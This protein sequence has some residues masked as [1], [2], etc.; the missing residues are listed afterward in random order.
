MTK[1]EFDN[2]K[3]GDAVKWKGSEH[4]LCVSGI[5]FR[6]YDFRR[7]LYYARFETEFPLSPPHLIDEN[8]DDFTVVPTVKFEKKWQAVEC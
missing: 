1:T 6:G 2:L 3:P 5:A 8:L 4:I 7:P